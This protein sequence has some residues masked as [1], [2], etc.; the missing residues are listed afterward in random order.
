ME[1]SKKTFQVKKS[2]SHYES[3]AKNLDSEGRGGHV[4]KGRNKAGLKFG[5]IIPKQP[6]FG[7]NNGKNMPVIN[8]KHLNAFIPFHHFKMGNLC[9]IKD[10]MQEGN[11]MCK[12]DLKDAYFSIPVH[13]KS[14]QFVNGKGSSTSFFACALG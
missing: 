13:R 3:L 7:I 14:T 6:L 11:L 12:V 9:M 10:I 1:I 2:C 5:G 4:G 8:L